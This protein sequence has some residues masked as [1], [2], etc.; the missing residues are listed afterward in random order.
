M[1]RTVT[2]TMKQASAILTGD[3]HL[4]ED[5]P[6]CRTDD[7]QKAQWKKV[8]YIAE[9]QRKHQCPVLHSGDLFEH[10]KPSPALL[11]ATIAALPDRFYSVAGNH[12]LPQH[13]ME[14]LWK[15]G[16][17][18]LIQAKRLRLIPGGA[19]WGEAPDDVTG[20][21]C[22]DTIQDKSVLVWHIMTW[23]GKE[24]W[25]GCPDPP[26]KNLLKKYSQFDLIL[27]GHNHQTF[28]EESAGRWL[29]NP[30]SLTRH[31]ADQE[32][33]KPCVFLWYA[34]SN[35]IEQVFLPCE[36][37]V[38]S[39]EHIELTEKRDARITAFVER[40]NTEWQKGVSFEEN[41]ERFQ[42]ANRIPESIMQIIRKAVDR[43]TD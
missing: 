7:F 15:S 38:I 42:Q 34:K 26:A 25:P 19:H 39:R 10:W 36:E 6:I 18:V 29:V 4:R 40:L 28:T 27:T 22:G 8:E 16:M 37:E 43:E 13:N 17:Y 32:D 31:K 14:L 2:R 9:L 20:I 35:T 1:R 21:V 12:D 41:L 3:W 24:P 5:T 33:H 11:S 23:K 30:G